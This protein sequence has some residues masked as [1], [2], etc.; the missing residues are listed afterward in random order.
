MGMKRLRIVKGSLGLGFRVGVH[1][2]NVGPLDLSPKFR[3]DKVF[4][5]LD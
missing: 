4:Q 3:V 5:T 2:W 1:G